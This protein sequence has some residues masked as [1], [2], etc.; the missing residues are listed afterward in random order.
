LSFISWVLS[1]KSIPFVS[2]CILFRSQA[3]LPTI[4][5]ARERPCGLILSLSVANSNVNLKKKGTSYNNRDYGLKLGFNL[6]KNLFLK[7]FNIFLVLRSEIYVIWKHSTDAPHV[8]P[9][10][11]PKP[12]LPTGRNFGRK[13]QKWPHK[14]LSGREKLRPNFW[15]IFQKMAEKWPNFYSVCTSHKSLHYLKK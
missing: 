1:G 4:E 2:V 11:L 5:R 13:T 6:N 8:L 12:V 15:P 9:I 3:I 14:N 10:R 7:I